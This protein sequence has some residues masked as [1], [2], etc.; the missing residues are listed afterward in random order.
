MRVALHPADILGA[1]ISRDLETSCS[2]WKN[3]D[4]E[5]IIYQ[6]RSFIWVEY[7]RVR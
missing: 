7:K 1:H 2:G 3:F 6:R 4:A 5:H